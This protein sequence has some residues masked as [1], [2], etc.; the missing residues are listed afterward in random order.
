MLTDMNS[1]CHKVLAVMLQ[2]YP[3]KK[4]NTMFAMLET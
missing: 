3:G 1:K 2:D 4:L